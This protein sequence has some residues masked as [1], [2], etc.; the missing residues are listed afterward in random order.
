MGE[1]GQG[2]GA[3]AGVKA[4]APLIQL[5]LLGPEQVHRQGTAI[6]PAALAFSRRSGMRNVAIEGC[7]AS[8]GIGFEILSSDS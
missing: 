2:G 3:E 8:C 5:R 6:Y 7:T 1:G 4:I